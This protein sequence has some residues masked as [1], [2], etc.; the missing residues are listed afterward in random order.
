MTPA[1]DLGVLGDQE[2][3]RI[4]AL[5]GDDVPV[6]ANQVMAAFEAHRAAHPAQCAQMV[7]EAH[8]HAE[9]VRVAAVDDDDDSGVIEYTLLPYQKRLQATMSADPRFNDS[10]DEV[11]H[12]SMCVI[13]KI[14]LEFGW[15]RSTLYSDDINGMWLIFGRSIRALPSRCRCSIYSRSRRLPNSATLSKMRISRAG[16]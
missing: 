5:R 7:E 9:A 4:L 8:A 2:R 13:G 10:L 11:E 6:A 12:M 14:A 3:A 15:K 1:T 16:A